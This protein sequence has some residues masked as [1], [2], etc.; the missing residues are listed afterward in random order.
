MDGGALT[1]QLRQS[2]GSSGGAAGF[3]AERVTSALR[4]REAAIDFLRCRRPRWGTISS[5]HNAFCI[6]QFHVITLGWYQSLSC[7]SAGRAASGELA[8]R[9]GQGSKSIFYY[10]HFSS[11][12]LVILP[13]IRRQTELI[14]AVKLQASFLSPG[15]PEMS[16]KITHASDVPS[17]PRFAWVTENP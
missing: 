6:S 13:E 11:A 4:L 9:L 17:R 3:A 16:I 15:P 7:L 10:R 1:Q 5:A 12:I 14:C 8:A 2:G